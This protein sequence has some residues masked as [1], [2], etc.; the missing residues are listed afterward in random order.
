MARNFNGSSQLLTTATGFPTVSPPLTMAYWGYCTSNS[1]ASVGMSLGEFGAAGQSSIAVGMRGDAAGDPVRVGQVGS[2]GNVFPFADT[3]SGYSINTWH[4]ACGVFSSN[5]S[6]SAFIDGGSKATNTTSPDGADNSNFASIGA[7]ITRSAPSSL[8]YTRYFLG[9]I[10]YP[11]IWNVALTDAEVLSLAKGVHPSLVR[12][13][14]ITALWDLTGGFSPEPDRFKGWNATLTG[15]PSAVDNPRILF[16]RQRSY[17]Y[18]GIAEGGDDKEGFGTITAIGNV[19]G[20]GSTTR[21]GSGSFGAVGNLVGTGQRIASAAGA[22]VAIGSLDGTGQKVSSASG[23]ITAIGIL[24]GTGLAPTVGEQSGFGTITAIGTL[25]ATGQS[26]RS[27]SGSFAAIGIL[28]G[29]GEA[30]VVGGAS[31]SGIVT[32]IGS[33]TGQ[34]TAVRSGSG[35]F[36]AVGEL[37]GM[38]R[39][40]AAASG[41]I[42]AVGNIVGVGSNQQGSM[43]LQYY[44]YLGS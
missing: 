7:Q 5:T 10:A 43:I 4:H 33:L 20:S 11:C 17:F 13:E 21:S 12:P 39:M 6:R 42:S 26:V 38:G 29:T 31:G 41:Q 44:Y 14:A 19:T 1:H 3:T 24:E 9:R 27:G 32:A 18:A 16:P 28:E 40:V 34:A 35:S 2:N 22:I 15:S 37:S 36:G 25:T 30:P 23:T 8:S